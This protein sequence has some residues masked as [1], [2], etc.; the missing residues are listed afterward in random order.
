MQRRRR[1]EDRQEPGEAAER[2]STPA[3]AVGLLELQQSAGNAAVSRMLA[4]T[5]GAPTSLSMRGGKDPLRPDIGSSEIGKRMSAA[6]DAVKDWLD[7]KAAA[8]G[9]AGFRESVPEL[10]AAAREIE[11]VADVYSAAEVEVI[12]RERAKFIGLPLTETRPVDDRTGVAAEAVARLKNLADKIPTEVTVGGDD[13]SI[14]IGIG[15]ISSRLKPGGG[16]TVEGEISPDGAK[17]GVKY[18][19]GKVGVSAD[20]KS[21]KL[22][23]KAGDL[24]SVKGSV[25]REGEYFKW[26]ADVQ[27]GTLG[28]VLGAE[29]IAKVLAGTQKT[30]GGAAQDLADGLQLS[31]VTKHGG[32]VKDAVGGAVEKAKKSAE[33]AKAGWQVGVSVQGGGKDGGVSAVVTLTWVF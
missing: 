17:V 20:Q 23:L 27:I 10:V 9:N 12:L 14:T 19:G 26:K 16:T 2:P 6:T 24:V 31:D 1:E 8:T 15:G 25:E 7:A 3:P 32:A 5:P 21:V 30:L 22:D 33:Q 13:A 11:G 29:D 18:P 4:R 28:K